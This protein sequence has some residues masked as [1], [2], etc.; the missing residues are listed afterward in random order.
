MVVA[1]LIYLLNSLLKSLSSTPN[2]WQNATHCCNKSFTDIFWN[3]QWSQSH[4]TC[5]LPPPSLAAQ[6][7]NRPHSGTPLPP[8]KPHFWKKNFAQY[9]PLLSVG[10]LL[11]LW[12]GASAIASGCQWVPMCAIANGGADHLLPSDNI[13]LLYTSKLLGFKCD[14]ESYLVAIIFF[15]FNHLEESGF[16]WQ[17]WYN[18]DVI[19]C[20]DTVM[21]LLV[22]TPLTDGLQ[23][24]VDQLLDPHWRLEKTD[25]WKI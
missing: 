6:A 21:T 25:Y 16:G 20:D 23:S 1:V 15:F 8:A 22:M 9:P 7:E 2:P 17:S 19:G 11:I 14:W 18:C 4:D 24:A 13:L 12:R 5:C 3:V 10:H